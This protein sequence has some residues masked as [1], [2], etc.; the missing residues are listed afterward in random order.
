[1]GMRELFQFLGIWWFREFIWGRNWG[2]FLHK[3]FLHLVKMVEYGL[4]SGGTPNPD[5]PT[6]LILKTEVL[7][8]ISIFFK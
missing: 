8:L 6:C 5:L 3:H 1:M 7:I 2:V 4:W